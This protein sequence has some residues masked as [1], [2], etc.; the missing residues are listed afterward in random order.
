MK[1]LI[2]FLAMLL[3]TTLS[4]QVSVTTDGSSPDPSAMLDVKS[5]NKGMLIPR[6]ALSAINS[7]S[8]ITSPAVGLLVYN[9]ATAGTAPN[10]VIPGFYYWNG[11]NWVSV[12]P[13]QGTTAGDMLYWDGTRWVLVPAGNP[14]QTLKL[15]NG[16]PTWGPCTPAVTTTEVFGITQSAATSGGIITDDGGA[17]VTARGVCWNTTGN[18]TLA[19]A[20]TEDGSGTGAFASEITGLSS[21]VTYFLRAYA[22]NSAGT[23]YG[24]ETSFNAGGIDG[25][26]CPGTASVSYGGQTYNTVRIGSQ[27]W[28]KENL[29]IGTMITG[30]QAQADNQ[31]IEKYCYGNNAGSCTTWGGIYQWDELM[32]YSTQE[33]AQGICPAGWHVPS[34]AE[35]CTLT[36]YLDPTVVCQNTT[37]WTGTNGGG[38]MKETGTAHWWSPNGGATNSSGFTGIGGGY[39]YGGSFSFIMSVGHWWTSSTNGSNHGLWQLRYNDGLV[40]YYRHQP[41]YGFSVRCILNPAPGVST[42]AVSDTTTNSAACGG[43]VTLNGGGEV[44][45]RGVCWNTTSGP[46]I[47]DSF[48]SDGTGAGTFTSQLTGLDANT[49]YFV[50]AYATTDGGTTYGN[51]VNFKTLQATGSNSAW[52]LAGNSGTDP[53]TNFIGTTDNKPLNFRV[54]GQPA[55]IIHPVSGNTILGYQTFLSN[56]TGVYNSGYGQWSLYSNTGGSYNSAFGR[57]SLMNNTEGVFNSAYGDGSLAANESGSYNSAYGAGSIASNI[58][59]I[60]NAAV[61]ESSLGLMTNGNYNTAIGKEALLYNITGSKNVAIGY[62]AGYYETDDNRLYIDNDAHADLADGREKSLI[63]GVFDTDPAIQQLTL[64]ANV[65][66]NTVTPEASAALDV[67]SI[68]KGLLPPRMTTEQIT[69]IVSPSAGLMVYNSTINKLQYFDGTAWRNSDGSHFIGESF[70]GGKVFFVYDNGL[71]GLIAATSDQSSSSGLPW[72]NYVLIITGTTGDGIKSGEMNTT[73]S[74]AEQLAYNPSVNFAAKACADFSIIVN[75]VNYGD[76]Y[77]PSKYELSL[78]YEQKDVV[79]GFLYDYYW[80]SNEYDSNS[81]WFQIFSD[82]SQTYTPKNQLFHVRAIRAF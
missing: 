79:G 67:S 4:A 72:S 80:S 36:T 43:T 21:G 71:H 18:P 76:W 74:I 59:G 19:D 15:C 55:G 44:T 32:N 1:T 64:N 51:Q 69:A 41:S 48:T 27:C 24:N 54:N 61:G 23:G 75:G 38:K 50:R 7:S 17:G 2:L 6:V 47:A 22:T 58:N 56:M 46:T 16:V 81:A 52:E 65:G 29:N 14:M 60:G 5:T 73:L 25:Q 10:D 34:D 53:S 8:P 66:I 62:H 57:Y 13:P 35:Y 68:T 49:T 37:S 45:S 40:G 70:G 28:F 31:V 39:S 11:I 42:S 33:G 12:V 26:T 63:Y 77:L 3:A 78:L 82:G 30:S 9:T 20:F